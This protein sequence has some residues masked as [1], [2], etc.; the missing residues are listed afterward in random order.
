MG[1][2]SVLGENFSATLIKSVVMGVGGILSKGVRESFKFIRLQKVSESINS[3]LKMF[4]RLKPLN[5]F[6]LKE[7][8]LCDFFSRQVGIFLLLCIDTHGCPEPG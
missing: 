1:G 3:S 6:I 7:I 5:F 2:D 8:K 4:L